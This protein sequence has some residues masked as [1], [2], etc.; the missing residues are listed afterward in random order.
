MRLPSTAAVTFLV[1]LVL[2][3]EFFLQGGALEY[4]RALLYSQPWRLFT[5]HFAHISLLHAMVNCVA[6]L[7]LERLFAERMRAWELWAVILGTPVVI[8]LAFWLAMPGLIW[9]RGLSAVLHALYFAGCV[10][11]WRTSIRRAR[12][13]PIVAIAGG[14]LKVLFEQ[15]WSETFPWAGWLGAPVV[16]QSHLIGALAGIAAGLWF[17]ARRKIQQ[18]R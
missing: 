12:W 15:P 16:P 2:A 4:R 14:A 8:S 11:W 17:A 3:A 18:T 6:L 7:L 5:G 10:L 1:L 9:F 13:L